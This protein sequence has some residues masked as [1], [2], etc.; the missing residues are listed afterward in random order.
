MVGMDHQRLTLDY[1]RPQKRRRRW[2][3]WITVASGVIAIAT[4]LYA[5]YV[6]IVVLVGL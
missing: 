2:G 6:L 1:A 4:V 5:G 3:K